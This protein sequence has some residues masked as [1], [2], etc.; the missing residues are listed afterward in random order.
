MKKKIVEEETKFDKE[1]DMDD[2]GDDDDEDN[3]NDG[4]DKPEEPD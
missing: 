3:P 2:F 4:Q 1:I